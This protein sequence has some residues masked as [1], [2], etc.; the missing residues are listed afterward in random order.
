MST[1]IFVIVMLHLL[2][3]FGYAI[4]KISGGSK[5]NSHPKHEP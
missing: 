3:G 5:N 4:Y 1:I 2:G